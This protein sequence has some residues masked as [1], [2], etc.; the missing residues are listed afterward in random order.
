MDL[1]EYLDM[2]ASKE[3]DY[4]N[5]AP[6]MLS[7]QDPRPETCFTGGTGEVGTT[8]ERTR[9]SEV[10]AEIPD[11]H[12]DSLCKPHVDEDLRKPPHIDAEP[13]L[14]VLHGS[15]PPIPGSHPSRSCC[16]KPLLSWRVLTIALTVIVAI[17]GAV[18]VTGRCCFVAMQIFQE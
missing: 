13:A 5:H 8:A 10:Y 1:G 7:N 15:L 16:N 6:K 14:Q 3:N 2:G 11:V 4:M 17:L 12:Y 18:L 9:D